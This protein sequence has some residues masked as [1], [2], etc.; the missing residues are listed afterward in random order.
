M[1]AAARPD[2]DPATVPAPEEI[3]PLFLRLAHPG[4]P[5][6]SGAVLEARDWIAR[7]PWEGIG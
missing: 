2:E 4:A 3:A 6:P 1:R 5:E 7:D